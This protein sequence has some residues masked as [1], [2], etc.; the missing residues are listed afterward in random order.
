MKS[1]AQHYSCQPIPGHLLN[2]NLGPCQFLRV[3]RSQR[4]EL[5]RRFQVVARPGKPQAPSAMPQPLQRSFEHTYQKNDCRSPQFRPP[6]P[7]RRTSGEV[8]N[9]HRYET[10][11]TPRCGTQLEDHNRF[12]LDI[13]DRSDEH[14]QGDAPQPELS[15]L[16][17]P[18]AALDSPKPSPEPT[19]ERLDP[20]L[21]IS[22]SRQD[23]SLIA[24][25]DLH[26]PLVTSIPSSSIL[27]S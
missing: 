6:C 11:L 17:L 15:A 19:K 1:Q 24:V 13:P 10:S 8:I 12:I 26:L 21:P 20:L 23:G 7:L 22:L 14:V 4:Q 9:F 2:S 27:S 25:Q 5:T 3:F 16:N 18:D